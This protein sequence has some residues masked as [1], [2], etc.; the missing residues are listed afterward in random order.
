MATDPQF[1]HLVIN[2]STLTD[3]VRITD[4]LDYKTAYYWR[5]R[6][7]NEAGYSAFS[8]V[9]R[10][11]TMIRPILPPT[12]LAI[13]PVADL[14]VALQWRDH[15]DNEEGFFIL[16]KEG[17]SLSANEYAL[18]GQVPAD[19]VRFTD[20]TVTVAAG[21]SYLIVAF[22]E[23]TVSDGGAYAFFQITGI[24]ERMSDIPDEYSLSQN[25]PNPFNPSTLIVF[26]LPEDA[27]VDIRIYD[28]S[29]SQ[30]RVITEDELK[31]GT[32][33]LRWDGRNDY[34]SQVPSGIYLCRMT[35]KNFTAVKKLMLVK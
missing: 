12:D 2:D 3:T 9:W 30:V 34:G 19:S 7:G 32:Y 33:R 14:R 4:S 18:I 16:R 5:L 25:Y 26:G 1:L 27:F 6:S 13:T 17:D 31:A 35:T 15:S 28:I 21:Y 23:D 10:F 24:E 11:T 8:P 29:G 20:T 22:N